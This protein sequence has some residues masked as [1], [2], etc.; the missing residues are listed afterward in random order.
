MGTKYQGADDEVRA[1]DLY[2]K[3]SRAADAV[4]VAVNR[5]LKEDHNLTVSQFGVL[6]AVYHL[7]PL[8]QSELAAKILKSSGNLTLVIDNL[9]R[10]GLVRRERDANDRRYVHVHLTEQGAAL[11][12]AI[13]PQHVAGIV[14]ALEVLS[15]AEQ[16]QLAH[17]CRV[18]GLAQREQVT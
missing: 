15:P 17:L 11:V 9:E 3:L 12:R 18:V 2:I 10:R 4:T 14:A 13:L 16:E 5:H 1:L 8:V 6:E 7:G